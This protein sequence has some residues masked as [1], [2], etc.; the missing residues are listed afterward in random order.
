MA[1]QQSQDDIEASAASAALPVRTMDPAAEGETPAATGELSKNAAKKAAKQ[2]KQAAEKAG[3]AANKGIGKSEAKTPV[4]KAP[5]KKIE[6]AAQIGIDVAKEDDFAAWYQQILLKGDMLDY[7]DVS[8]CFVLKPHSFFIWEEIQNWFNDKIKKMGVKNCSF[9]LFVSEDVLKKEKDHI[10]GFAAEVAWVTHAGSSPLEKKIAIRPTSETVMYPYYAKWIRSHRDLPLKLNQWNSVVRWEFK[11]PQP[12]LR[13]REFLW[14]EGHTAH[15]TES[16]AREEVLQILQHYAHVYEQLLAIPVIQGQKTDKEKFA[17]GLYTTTVEGYIPATGRGIQGGTSHGLGQNFSKMFGITVEDPTSTQDEK[18]P[19]LH[20]WQNSWGLSTRT[21][22]IM[23]M[24]HS[25]N[26]G[27]VLP[28]R[29]ADVQTVIVPVGLTAKTPDDVRTSINAEIDHL[30]SVLAA[31]GVRVE[32]DKREGY[33]PGWKFNDWELKGIPL[34]L[35]FGPGE[36]AGGFVT[37]SRRDVRGKDGKSTIRVAELATAVPKLLETIQADL[38]ARADAE[39]RS[40]VKLITRWEEFCPALNDKNLCMIPHC[41]TEQCEDEVKELSARKAEEET[42]ETVDA[43]MPS[44]GAKSLCI[45]FDQ[46][47]GIEKG[48]TKCTNPKC[49]RLA[50]QWCLFGRSY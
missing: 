36:S 35:E 47:A 48:V 32:V 21:I 14:Q 20:V 40:H 43:K 49:A 10:E 5:K 7:Y 15:F 24:V 23:V 33:S 9:P 18:K 29:V 1:S 4:V 26:N 34:R 30:A 27:L 25:D 39:F 11:N 46:P 19:P 16:A 28:P 8:G 41:L 13:T 6:G 42:G 44:M 37:T 17:G 50:E 38:Y 22:G 45:P 31:A 3:K 12:F 2:K